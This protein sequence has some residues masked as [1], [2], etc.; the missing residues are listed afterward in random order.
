MVVD[1]ADDLL[2]GL[3]YSADQVLQLFADSEEGLDQARAAAQ[4]AGCRIAAEAPVAGGATRFDAQIAADPPCWPR[5]DPP[6]T[7]IPF[8]TGSARPRERAGWRALWSR[9]ST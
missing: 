9:R 5:P 1:L 7:S 6:T 2:R 8:F 4:R 3:V